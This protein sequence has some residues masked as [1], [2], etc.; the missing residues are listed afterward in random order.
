[1]KKAFFQSAGDFFFYV[2]KDAHAR[3]VQRSARFLI[4]LKLRGGGGISVCGGYTKRLQINSQILKITA[5]DIVVKK[6]TRTI[7]L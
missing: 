7:I 5:P 1:M 2:V 6:T 3:T 4:H